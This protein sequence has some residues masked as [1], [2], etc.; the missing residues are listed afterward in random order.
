MFA[1]NHKKSEWKE[2]ASMTAPRS[3]FGATI[4][5]GKI[6]VVGGVNEEG[7]I[8][9]CEAYDFGTNKYVSFTIT[10]CTFKVIKCCAGLGFF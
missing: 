3:M 5:K 7:L 9:S 4:Y 2:V 8:A 10:I 6:I 1:Y